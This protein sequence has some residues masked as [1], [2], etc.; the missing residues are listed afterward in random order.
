MAQPS[1]NSP[2]SRF[3]FGD[4]NQPYFSH[5]IHMGGLGASYQ[6]DFQTNVANPASFA[7]LQSTS[8]E[9]G[10]YGELSNLQD[11]ETQA[12]S[13]NGNLT[14]LSLAF[15]L[16]NPIN[17]LLDRVDRDFSYGMNFSLIPY[18]RVGY[19]ILSSEQLE[20]VKGIT[21]RYIGQG[22]T[23]TLN[24]GNSLKYKDL[25]V[26][27]SAGYLFGNIKTQ[28]VIEFDSI[29]YAF[30]N[31]FENNYHVSGFVWNAGA[32]YKFVLPSKVPEEESIQ[33]IEKS[34]TVGVYGNSG[35][36]FRTNT[37]ELFL[38]IRQ[39]FA[40]IVD[41]ISSRTVRDIDGNGRLPGKFGIGAMYKHGKRWGLGVDYE[42]QNWSEYSN[43]ANP[44]NLADTYKFSAGG[45][46]KPDPNSYTNYFKRLHFQAGYFISRDASSL[47]S[48]EI[49]SQ[50]VTF[51]ITF[52][53][54][55]QR[56]ASQANIGVTLG[57]R[58]LTTPVEE[59]YMRLNFGFT[60]N[61]SD[62][63]IKRKYN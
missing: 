43:D 6:D 44:S 18:S 16:I 7:S 48:D 4:I 5:L 29:L 36:N 59:R 11:S 52:P 14:Y 30:N 37:D 10:L 55:T 20:G 26:G 31:L 27:I 42:I 22:G 2:Y 46:F 34:I 28:R 45:F 53:F 1:D 61:D 35:S 23:Y 49:I 51:G 3:G 21:R 50:G 63:F 17:D 9:V 13:W 8:F 38:A 47:T 58:G 19:E 40:Q 57:Q 33:V 41:T 15:P 56:K 54:I 25:S 32:Q 62:W 24:W 60:F 12:T 39:D